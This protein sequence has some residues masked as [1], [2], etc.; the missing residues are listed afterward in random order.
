MAVQFT[1][2]SQEQFEEFLQIDSKSGRP[3][4]NSVNNFF[5]IQVPGYKELVYSR[6]ADKE[7][8]ISLRILSTIENGFARDK[9]EDA[10]RVQLWWRE[11]DKAEPKLIGTEKSVKRIATWRDNLAE[12]IEMW[13][14][15][16]GPICKCGAPTNRRKRRNTPAGEGYFYG[17]VKWPNCPAENQD[18]TQTNENGTGKTETAVTTP[19][20][21][22]ATNRE[23]VPSQHLLFSQLHFLIATAVSDPKLPLPTLIEAAN[24]LYG[25]NF[26]RMNDDGKIECDKQ[27]INWLPT[28][29]RE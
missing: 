16:L 5:R 28:M 25:G 22:L 11:N 14:D 3:L 1:R 6:M 29:E 24:V 18:T 27:M 13:D 19:V 15:M 26:I 4:P 23:E 7:A 9:G 2:F 8:N 17:C 10:I 12:R 21:S 20:T